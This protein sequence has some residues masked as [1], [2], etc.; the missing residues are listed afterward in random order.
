MIK[1]NMFA[2]TFHDCTG[3]QDFNEF[4][5]AGESSEEI[6]DMMELEFSK[7]LS[8]FDK[9]VNEDYSDSNKKITES[10]NL[11]EELAEQKEQEGES[12]AE[13]LAKQKE[14]EGESAAEELAEDIINKK[15]NNTTITDSVASS[16]L[17][18]TE[19]SSDSVKEMSGLKNN[20][21][22][23]KSTASSDLSGTEVNISET[24]DEVNKENIIADDSVKEI[25]PDLGSN[26]KI[27]EDIPQDDNDSVLEEQIKIA[28]INEKDPEKKKRLWNEYRKYKGLPQKE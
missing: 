14:Q 12:A 25:E 28:A 3:I 7:S 19:V 18:G 23:K 15:L 4:L 2:Q 1:L 16:D 11:T 8:K 20:S 21:N 6:L 5:E 9:C 13:E 22:S 17:S 26:S 10:K 24:E 27:P